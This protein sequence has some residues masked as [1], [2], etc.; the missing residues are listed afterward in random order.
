M[1]KNN[2]RNYYIR[3]IN[4]HLLNVLENSYYIEVGSVSLQLIDR[5]LKGQVLE[6]K[7]LVYIKILNEGIGK[8]T[9]DLGNDYDYQLNYLL[10]FRQK[11]STHKFF[12]TSGLLK[13][14]DET[15]LEKFAPIVLIPIDIDYQ[16]RKIRLSSEPILNR[17]LMRMLAKYKFNKQEDQN[18][19]IDAQSNIRLNSSFAID[20]VCVELAEYFKLSVTPVNYLTICNVEYY[21][22]DIKKDFFSPERSIYESKEINI[23]NDYFTKVK[24]ILP[25]N[26]HQKHAILR[27]HNGENFAVD[28][29][30]GSGKTYT[31]INIIADAIAKDKK[32]LYV[33]QDLDNVWE[34]EKNMKYFG[35]DNLVVNLTTKTSNI[36]V[37]PVILPTDI[38]N[39]F[40]FEPIKF[41]DKLEEARHKRIGGF[42][43]DYLIEN[44]AILKRLYKDIKSIKLEVRLERYEYDHVKQLLN[45]IEDNLKVIGDFSQNVWRGLQPGVT[46]MLPS[47]IVQR[48]NDFY[49]FHRT[50][51]KTID[52]Y[53]ESYNLKE[54]KNI[55]DLNNLIDHVLS[56]ESA[57][58]QP[59][60]KSKED[61]NKAR[62][63]LKEIQ[64]AIDENYSAMD[65]YKNNLFK[66]YKPGRMLDILTEVVGKHLSITS[67]EQYINNIFA[68]NQELDILTNTIL[69]N[70]KIAKLEFNN[71]Y[72]Y[73]GFKADELIPLNFLKDL[74]LYLKS[75]SLPRQLATEYVSNKKNALFIGNIIYKNYQV[76][77]RIKQEIK[78]ILLPNS[79]FTY[80]EAIELIEDAKTKK[81]LA[82]F[83]DFAQM[84]RN[85][86]DKDELIKKISDYYHASK[87]IISALEIKDN[88]VEIEKYWKE[89]SSFYELVSVH[90]EFSK[91]FEMFIKKQFSLAPIDSGK[92]TSTLTNIINCAENADKYIEELKKYNIIINKEYPIEKINELSSW[93]SYLVKAI[94][95]RNETYLC[96]N[97]K[98]IKFDD[99][100]E[101]I[102]QD[103]N[104]INLLAKLSQNEPEYL[105]LLGDNYKKFDTIIGDTGISIDHFDDFIEKLNDPDDVDNL[106]R[107]KTFEKFVKDTMKLRSIQS[108][109]FTFYRLFS[110]CFTHGQ[111]YCQ[112]APFKD[113]LEMLKG[114][115]LQSNQIDSAISIIG[116]LNEVSQ[117]GLNDLVNQITTGKI[118]E[119]LSASFCYTLYS[120]YINEFDKNDHILIDFN[121]IKSEFDEFE[122]N[123]QN[124]CL[125]NIVSLK[126]LSMKKAKA[127]NVTAAFY[128]Y[129]KFIE[130]TIK[131]NN[132]Y[133]ADLNIFNADLDVSKF[134]LVI[135]DDCHLSSA[136][137]YNRIALCKQVVLLGD[138]SFQS[139]VANSLLQRIGDYSII[140]YANRYVKMTPKFN[141]VW[142]NANRYIYSYET[143]VN[144]NSINSVNEFGE[145]IV[146]YF[147]KHP[148]NVLNVLIGNEE[149]RREVYIAVVTIL[150]MSYSYMDVIEILTYHIRLINVNDEGSKYVNDVF[151]YYTDFTEYDL[152]QKNLIFKNFVVVENSV[153]IYYLANKLE[154]INKEIEQDIS[155]T[156]VKAVVKPKSFDGI[157]KVVYDDLVAH[158]IK[159]KT[160][161]GKFDI[162]IQKSSKHPIAIIFEGSRDSNAFSVIDDYHYY[163]RQ[164]LK[165]GWDIKVI[166][167]YDL[168]DNYDKIFEKLLKEI[169]GTINK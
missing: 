127:K 118:R 11:S 104:Y 155:K 115:I 5:L 167:T 138:K 1:R 78:S 163:Y 32:I 106:L 8:I 34:I 80:L 105:R 41:F 103:N 165:R 153:Q 148:Q 139:S 164:Y 76:I 77:S 85:R 144:I 143:S 45:I 44:Q 40:D 120:E 108:E 129:N 19:Y 111:P 84:R 135:I 47:E 62:V 30:L 12:L 168:I 3:N 16:K 162:T 122:K 152:A 15:G 112:T 83:F 51:T 42:T 56:F 146:E 33:N 98:S 89:C 107:T 9:S 10:S 35:L 20:K 64:E 93:T 119:R 66:D 147:V 69:E 68:N 39:K 157:A 96:V 65:Y 158:G 133:L 6:L 46:K 99:I 131:Y 17:L 43:F 52:S 100:I 160:G 27:A 38:S 73:F 134:D 117:Y 130:G 123:E 13:Y 109:W 75:N 49:N 48:L 97:K 92:V 86:I 137:K 145:K 150:N 22:F 169:E 28:G 140:Q 166:Y 161:F 82:N 88:K 25:A 110:V 23:Y 37:A 151:I 159:V 87:N 81:R 57:K 18:K 156:M 70:N 74:L 101:L 55:H 116:A 24:S 136:N 14:R 63:V 79:K 36:E 59:S 4:T 26:L 95:L 50:L 53:C 142:N 90:S 125:N 2:A 71:L 67:D 21:D 113:V 102:E 58:P 141:N 149:T 128:E 94:N 121:W 61:R 29:K 154:S 124:Y 114:F 72:G 31:A 60:W 54:P 132:L 91:N 7:D 126:Q